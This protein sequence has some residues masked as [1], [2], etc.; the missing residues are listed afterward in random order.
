MPQKNTLESETEK[1][2]ANNS[3]PVKSDMKACR[4]L[5]LACNYT[6]EQFDPSA[7]QPTQIAEVT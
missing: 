5:I 4:R 6:E 2:H 1:K 3:F 7:Q